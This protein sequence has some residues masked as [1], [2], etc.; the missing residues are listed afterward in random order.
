MNI[1]ATLI[2]QSITFLF[3]VLFCMKYVWPALL[4][5]MEQRERRIN[6]GLMAAEQASKDLDLAKQGA[7][8]QLEEAK[9]QASAIVEQANKRANQLIEQAK[10]QAEAEVERVKVTAQAAID[11]E[12][13][14]AREQ[15]RKKVATLAM[16]GA[17]RVLAKSI[18]ISA[19]NDMLNKLSAEL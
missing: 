3:F 7:E 10:A 18:D 9:G 15:L 17:E 6:D 19:H 14:L 16:V 13:A 11:R 8:K 4:S 2:G 12:V 5:V 1:T